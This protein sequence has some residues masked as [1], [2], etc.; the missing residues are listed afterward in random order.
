VKHVHVSEVLKDSIRNFVGNLRDKLKRKDE[1]KPKRVF[2]SIGGLCFI[3]IKL[4]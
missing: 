4:E 2:S 3:S 1:L